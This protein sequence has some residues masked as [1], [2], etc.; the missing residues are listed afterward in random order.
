MVFH[1]RPTG[2]SCLLLGLV[3]LSAQE[4]GAGRLN[5]ADAIFL[6]PL[7]G[8]IPLADSMTAFPI[9]GGALV[10]LG[11]I[12][13]HLGFGIQV[14]AG[15]GQ[16]KGFFISE[17]RHFRLDLTT[18]L[19]EVEGRVLPLGP[20]LALREGQEIFVDA[21]LLEA[22]FPLKVKVDTKAAE[23]RFT[24]REKLPVEAEWERQGKA[25]GLSPSSASDAGDQS[26]GT[27]VPVP[28][29]LLDVPF[30]DVSAYW[31]KSQHGPSGPPSASTQVAGD[32]LWMSAD[33][34]ASR[35]AEGKIKN[36]VFTLFREDPHAELLGPLHATRVQLG[37]LTQ[38]T[39][40]DLAGGVPAGRG[41]LVDNFPTSFRSK[42]ASRTFQGQL[43]EGWTVELYQN[44]ALKAYLRVG[45]DG[46]YEIRDVPLRFGLNQFKLVFHGPFGQVREENHRVDIASDQP[47]PGTLY[48][49]LAGSKPLPLIQ[50]DVAGGLAKPAQP[51]A[52]INSLAELEY[53][54]TP[55]LAAS[56]AVGNIGNSTGVM[57]TYDVVGLRSV[58]SHLSLQGNLAQDQVQGRTPGL[59]AQGI[60]RTGYEY[61]T[62]TV[63]RSEYRRGFEKTDF[64]IYGNQPQH[65]RSE[66]LLQWDGTWTLGKMP[67]NLA[68]ATNNRRYAEGGGFRTDTLRTTFTF[69]TFVVAPSLSRSLDLGPRGI[70]VLSADVFL[71]LHRGEYDLQGTA[72]V[73]DTQGKIKFREWTSEV[74]REL[75]SGLT[76][77]VGLRG[78]DFSLKNTEL[79]CYVS[80]L[81]GPFGYGVDFQYGKVAGY[82]LGLRFQTSFGREPRTGKWTQDG[83]S[84]AGQGSASLIA[85]KDNNGNQTLDPGEPVLKET[86]FKVGNSRID[87][88][89]KD[90]N[91]V[92]KT[93]LPRAQETAIRVNESSLEDPSLQPTV[94]AYRIVPRPGKVIRLAFPVTVFGEI[95]GTTRIRRTKKAE[96]FGGLEL[97]LLHANGERVKRFRTAYD[98]FFELR[99]LPL[100]DY[101]LQVTPEEVDRIR[102]KEPTPRRLHID[103]EK[104]L[105]EG[106]DF[107][108]EPLYPEPE[109]TPVPKALGEPAA[110]PATVSASGPTAAPVLAPTPDPV[111][112]PPSKPGE[113]P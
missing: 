53:G 38:S 13:S 84:I 72:R 34:M 81:K 103:N 43:E 110:A 33:L 82:T 12:C 16:A 29:S 76:Y 18:R 104:S 97:E 28:Y 85:F 35:D 67:V 25:S 75:P 65:I 73:E 107:V 14:D 93:L 74:S 112:V 19:A 10:P 79:R 9:P 102:I 27:Y 36:T 86:E 22:W 40:L 64:Q 80:K 99:Q 32:L 23:V 11:E 6:Q 51:E 44:K 45:S 26:V 50:P 37:S 95:S 2:L 90:P 56:A 49:R 94:Q 20:L 70:A 96:D 59:A 100:G 3:S 101:I 46:R 91:V 109:F 62:L 7:L 63:D 105:F 4:P 58:F 5:P 47:P 108:V 30:V 78:Q 111:P 87:S 92:F 69:P 113:K 98:G 48:Y 1:C 68:L 8:K 66:T 24:G 57:H 77:H 42:F 21:R 39:S 88:A 83:R 15:K 89:I 55:Y 17:K 52:R 106:Q 41:I 60:L 61:S 31:A 71:N 54:L